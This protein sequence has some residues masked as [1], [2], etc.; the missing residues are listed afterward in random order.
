MFTNYNSLLNNMHKIAF[1]IKDNM[2]HFSDSQL[3]SLS[4]K[5]DKTHVK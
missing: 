2:W 1:K 3:T 5:L 4:K